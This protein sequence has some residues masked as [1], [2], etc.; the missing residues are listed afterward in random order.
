MMSLI[1]YSILITILVGCLP[2]KSKEED[3]RS[4]SD[5]AVP[6]TV[7]VPSTD[8]SI[9]SE[10]GQEMVTFLTRFRYERS[11]VVAPEVCRSEVQRSGCM[12]GTQSPYTGTYQFETCEILPQVVPPR[13]CGSIAHGASES[14]IRFESISVPMGSSCRQE[15]QT[16]T[17]QNGI[18]SPFSGTFQQTSCQ[19]LTAQ[20]CGSLT[21]GQTESRTMFQASSVPFGSQ[22]I[23][24]LQSRTC[25]NGLL[26]AYNG[27]YQFSTCAVA[28]PRACASLAHGQTQS[29][30]RYAQAQVPHGEQCQYETQTATCHDGTLSSF[31]GT[32]TH[33]ACQ[34]NAQ[35]NSA[36]FFTSARSVL[37]SSCL[38]C[39]GPGAGS[40]SFNVPINST[41]EQWFQLIRSGSNLIV[42]G[43]RW[44]DS[45][46]LTRTKLHTKGGS[47]RTMPLVGSWTQSDYQALASWIQ[48]IDPMEVFEQTPRDCGNIRHG[49][50]ENRLRYQSTSVA[51]GA[52]CVSQIQ[53][54]T[55]NDGNLSAF[56]GTY[57]A[58]TCNIQAPLSCGSVVHGNSQTRQRFQAAS[59]PFGSQCVQETQTRT[60]QNGSFTAYS[61]TFTHATCVVSKAE[62]C[63]SLTHGQTQTRTMFKESAVAYNQ[64]CQSEVQTR[65]CQNG[66]LS[67][68]SGSFQN[69]SCSVTPGRNCTNPNLNHNQTQTRTRYRD[70]SVAAGE[71]CVSEVQTR[72]C[73]DGTVT[74]F[75]GSFT[76]NACQVLNP[77]SLF[78]EARAVL[79]SK[80]M[81]CHGPSTGVAFGPSTGDD[82]ESWYN[83]FRRGDQMLI[84]GE[85][86][87][88]SRLLLR[89]KLHTK[90]GSSRTMPTSGS[91]T[92]ANYDALANWIR[93]VK[94][95]DVHVDD[96]PIF[97]LPIDGDFQL[98]GFN[99]ILGERIFIG[100]VLQKLFTTSGNVVLNQ[101]FRQMD[102]FQGGCDMY[103]AARTSENVLEFNNE[104][105]SGTQRIS[106][107][108]GISSTVREGR[109]IQVCHQGIY[110][111][112]R[113][114]IAIANLGGLNRNTRPTR[115]NVIAALHYFYPN[116][117][118]GTDTINLILQ[119]VAEESNSTNAWRAVLFPICASPQWQIL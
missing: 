52:T 39:H 7:N 74:S 82:V 84:A 1:K 76:H 79:D 107:Q 20:S 43:E 73:I 25:I 6:A 71:T 13:N 33:S 23:S 17:C 90:G 105:C 102:F 10:C 81:G 2:D 77:A 103:E 92:Q 112:T 80:C 5:I 99:M 91:W 9:N 38:N 28:S 62:S 27:N 100:N 66:I 85:A 42:A 45:T 101:V 53:T 18:L 78:T 111:N 56:S 113:L 32:Y 70:N 36:I 55:C 115:E 108:I 117:N 109:R 58:E 118:F 98:Q 59:V 44:D 15:T 34:I 8:S 49:T 54:R 116:I 96:K 106:D 64:T 11:S 69:T 46:I 95:E 72:R 86:W 67:A 75:S 31:S 60:C 37:E 63:G 114:D 4:V 110:N 61:G 119:K 51:F 65:T 47:A 89:T 40:L 93:S 87:D 48:A 97:P 104:A 83:V 14:R 26:T 21:N 30:I 41:Q 88:D 57:T 16:R 94:P 24:Q 29:R 12:N 22:C 50:S 68:F 35:P 19:V 3:K